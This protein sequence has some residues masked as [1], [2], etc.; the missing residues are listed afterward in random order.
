MRP[1][2][3]EKEPFPDAAE[4]EFYFSTPAL[5]ACLEELGR[6]IESGHVLL[7]DDAG[8]GKTTMLENFVESA[9]ERWRIF[10]LQA[11]EHDDA[12]EFAHALVST[13]GLPLREPVAAELRD[14]DTLLELLTTR[15]QFAVIVID[16]VHRLEADAL[17]QLLY[18]AK[19]WEGYSVRFLICAE[20]ALIENLESLP[21]DNG[22][23]GSVTT[24]AMPR[25]DHEQVG[26]YLHMCLFRAGLVGDSPFDPALVS[27][28]VERARGLVGAIDPIA[29][30]LL[31]EAGS[32][33]RIR[34]RD[35]DARG[36]SRRWPVAVVA[37]AGL[38]A[39]LTVAVPGISR[40]PG[41][42]QS[43]GHAE[44]FR[45]GITPAPRKS[46]GRRMERSAAA[47]S[48]GP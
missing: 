4:R 18:L 1:F 24:L 2:S 20:P 8:S 5:T 9:N 28:V 13:F 16:D 10:R 22:F 12:K 38:G 25:F 39:L 44:V 34:G 40:S 23:P 21:E 14:A 15:S 35:D 32:H 33:G 45:S 43:Q 31:D 27:T 17:E 41:E 19:R 3:L 7:V 6:S 47:D 46:A 30:E 26:D 29:R 11:R 42:A 48:A 36:V 37:A